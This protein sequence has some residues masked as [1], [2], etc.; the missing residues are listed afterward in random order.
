MTQ[1]VL[2]DTDVIIAGA[3]PVGMTVAT[4]LVRAGVPCRIIDKAAGPKTYSQ[5]GVIWPRTQEALEFMG[6][7]DRWKPF[8]IPW[9][10]L[11]VMGEFLQARPSTTVDIH[12]DSHDTA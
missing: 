7:L 10:G 3:G 5:A 9:H 11:V 1:A 8:S 2:N 4:E 6:I 12:L